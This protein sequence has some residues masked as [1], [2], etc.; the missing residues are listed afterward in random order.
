MWAWIARDNTWSRF[1]AMLNE[2]PR[3]AGADPVAQ[4]MML[5]ARDNA[6]LAERMAFRAVL[7]GMRGAA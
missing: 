6:M 3:D 1:L 5:A 4:N 2:P 7:D